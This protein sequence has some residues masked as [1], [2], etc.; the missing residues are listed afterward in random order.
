MRTCDE[1]LMEIQA[2]GARL[3]SRVAWR[4]KVPVNA[5]ATSALLVL[6][7]FVSVTLSGHDISDTAITEQQ[8]YGSLVLTS[9][10]MGLVIINV[11]SFM[12]GVCVTL[13][14]LH[15]RDRPRG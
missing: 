13:L 5:L 9:P 2:R 8:A 14:C 15:L 12:L 6:L 11:L 10:L 4:R 7:A 1:Q 3:K